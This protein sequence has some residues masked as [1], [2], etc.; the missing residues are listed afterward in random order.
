MVEG[1]QKGQSPLNLLLSISMA[2]ITVVI[3]N[4]IHSSLMENLLICVSRFNLTSMYN[5]MVVWLWEGKEAI[6]GPVSGISEPYLL[7]V[8]LWKVVSVCRFFC[9]LSVVCKWLVSICGSSPSMPTI[10]R[11]W[12]G[13]R[14]KG[15]SAPSKEMQR[16]VHIAWS[17]H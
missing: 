14:G 8:L 13:H 11:G 6:L 15:G 10:G 5:F 7:W 17:Y 16:E 2:I 4:M 12:K 3:S 9:V 1:G